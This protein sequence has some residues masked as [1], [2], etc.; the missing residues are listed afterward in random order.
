MMRLSREKGLVNDAGSVNTTARAQ[1]VIKSSIYHPANFVIPEVG[2]S[3]YLIALMTNIVSEIYPLPPTPISSREV[4]TYPYMP[5]LVIS[6]PQVAQ[7]EVDPKTLFTQ[8]L[9]G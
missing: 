3:H 9:S 6:S 1:G 5:L 2:T 8:V 4:Y 7:A